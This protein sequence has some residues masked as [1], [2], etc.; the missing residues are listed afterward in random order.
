MSEQP[1]NDSVN[2]LVAE[3]MALI[4]R[5]ADAPAERDRALANWSAQSP[6]HAEAAAMAEAEL[7]LYAALPNPRPQG[8]ERLQI[9]AETIAAQAAEHPARLSA[10]AI[11]LI[12]LLAL[13]LVNLL[14]P[15]SPMVARVESELIPH[16]PA[17]PRAVSYATA[18]GERERVVLED[19]SAV[20]LD[21]DSKIQTLFIDGERHVDLKRGAAVFD[22]ADDPQRPFIVHVGAAVAKVI[23]TE[24]AVNKH[25]PEHI[26]FEV[27]EGVVAVNAVAGGSAVRLT[28]AKAVS[29]E[30]GDLGKVRE[31]SLD[32]IGAWRDGLLVFDER[33]LVEVLKDLSRYTT[34]GLQI[35]ALK[36]PES[37]VTATF[38]IDDADG[39]VESL[40]DLFALETDLMPNGAV[41]IRSKPE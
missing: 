5:C 39:A 40:K 27:K 19:G 31:T 36:N 33:A 41:L 16:P 20:W 15:F 10:A 11:A 6:E 24:F 2:D 38:F 25:N 32:T 12:A 9:A 28:Q 7:A 14:V 17:D 22:V 13:P 3:A 34:K 26:V 37:P 18:H 8:L 4:E 21:W 1:T 35:G 23:G 29:F 30:G